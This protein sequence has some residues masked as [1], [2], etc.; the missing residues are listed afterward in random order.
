M[1]RIRFLRFI[2]PLRSLHIASMR[3]GQYSGKYVQDLD[4]D[5][6][7]TTEARASHIELARGL[8]LTKTLDKQVGIVGLN[9]PAIFWMP[10]RGS[11]PIA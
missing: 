9:R 2:A 4:L 8:A 5:R 7:F 10:P 1:S 6:P 11:S 3:P